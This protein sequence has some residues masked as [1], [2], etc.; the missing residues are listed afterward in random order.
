MKMAHLVRLQDSDLNTA[1]G[2]LQVRM[3]QWE[4]LK[5]S[6][7]EPGKVSDGLVVRVEGMVEADT[8]PNQDRHLT[9]HARRN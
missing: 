2:M 8:T 7:P 4:G 9:K 3:T 1:L 6:F 5:V